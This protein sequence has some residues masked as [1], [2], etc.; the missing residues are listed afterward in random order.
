MQ[1]CMHKQKQ[2]TFLFLVAH[3]RLRVEQPPNVTT[4]VALQWVTCGS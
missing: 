2:F 4:A 3:A 1:A